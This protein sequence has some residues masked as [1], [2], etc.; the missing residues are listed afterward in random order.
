VQER[1]VV[2]DLLRLALDVLLGGDSVR[3]EAIGPQFGDALLGLDVR[4]HLRLRVRGLIGLVVPEAAVADQIDQHVVAELLAEGERQP[5]RAHARRH[6]VRVDVDDRHVEALGQVR[7]PARRARVVGVGG[8][9]DLVVR[10]QVDAPT[11]LVAVERLKVERLRDNAL[12]REG[13]VAVDHDRHRRVGVLVRMRALARGLRRPRG[14]LDDRVDVLEVARV[15]LQVDADRPP[16]RQLVGALSAVVVL[17]VAGAPLGN[18][19]HG[20]E[21]RGASNSAKIV[22]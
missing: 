10:D 21:R 22:S 14:A 1:E 11:D 5:R 16:V 7:G 4:V 3:D 9:A 8:E 2:P 19:R 18:G 6:V 13:G 12:G 17:D 15:G 20:L